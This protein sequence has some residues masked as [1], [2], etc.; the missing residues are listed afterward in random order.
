MIDIENPLSSSIIKCACVVLRQSCFDSGIVALQQSTMMKFI[1]ATKKGPIIRRL[2][3]LESLV[4][5][6]HRNAS[7]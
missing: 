2:D 5:K 3:P 4:L 6:R 1:L 7:L